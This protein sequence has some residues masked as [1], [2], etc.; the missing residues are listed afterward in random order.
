M[1]GYGDTAFFEDGGFLKKICGDGNW[2]QVMLTSFFG[3]QF[4]VLG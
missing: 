2:Q 4:I 1:G 3:L